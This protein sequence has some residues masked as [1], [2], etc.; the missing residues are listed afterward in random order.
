MTASLDPNE[1]ARA[2]DGGEIGA[3]VVPQAPPPWIVRTGAWIAL[4]AF[5]GAVL[6]SIL[7]RIPDTVESPFFLASSADPEPGGEPA[8]G[9]V[10]AAPRARI[11]LEERNLTRFAPGQRVRLSFEAYPPERFGT[12][13]GVLERAGAASETTPI[14]AGFVGTVV[15]DSATIGGR[16]PLPLRVGMR[17]T[18]RITVGE[19]TIAQVLLGLR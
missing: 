3:P 10:G 17:G 9:G 1:R 2:G 11:L 7:V 15:L 8:A 16:D 4:A 13:T 6:G 14:G 18:A 19:R 5:V 12:V